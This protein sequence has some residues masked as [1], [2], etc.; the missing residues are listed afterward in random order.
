MATIRDVALLAG[1]SPA[2]VSRVLNGNYPVKAETRV[3]VENAIKALDFHPNIIGRSLSA[4]TKKT[5]FVV[6]STALS[7]MFTRV[8]HGINVTTAQNGYEFL[9]TILDNSGTQDLKNNWNR[10][11]RHIEDGLVGGVILLGRQVIETAANGNPIS[12]PVVQCSE[13]SHSFFPN[14]VSYDNRRA[15]YDL[16]NQLIRQGFRRFGF[17]LSRKETENA[18]SEFSIERL[19]GMKK[20][21]SEHG[22]PYDPEL[23][24][25][26]IQHSDTY[27]LTTFSDTTEATHKYMDMR[28]EQRPDILL[29]SYDAIAISCINEFQRAG[30]Q[31][32]RDIGI[33]GFDNVSAAL[34]PRPQLT[35]VQPPSFEM[36]VE[37]ARLLIALMSGERTGGLTIQLPY[38][39]YER[40]STN[41]SLA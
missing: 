17:L 29:C 26:C 10:C 28:P 30:L 19:E 6:A 20:A 22:I 41:P 21:L 18:P 25:C 32:P 27:G 16:T 8:L 31:I 5:I 34:L 3:I 39:I 1:V 33:A 36:G 15:F 7:E 14:C 11:A 38:I 37:A 35:S 9:M 4:H 23:T 24:I 12:V 40:G 2:T 13:S